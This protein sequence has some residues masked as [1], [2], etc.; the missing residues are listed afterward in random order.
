MER[1]KGCQSPEEVLSEMMINK[2]EQHDKA[3]EMYELFYNT[4]SHK[5]RI[6][7]EKLLDRYNRLYN[8]K[9][10]LNKT[11]LFIKNYCQ[12]LNDTQEKKD[13]IHEI[14]NELL[15][16]Y[17]HYKNEYIQDKTNLIGDNL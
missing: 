8:M 14:I 9:R 3:F 5:D 15:I 13:A 12:N 2:I 11:E 1:L 16:K 7:K 4:M 10:A 6:D 17:E